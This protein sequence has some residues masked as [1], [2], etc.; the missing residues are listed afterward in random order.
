[1]MC[2][3]H[4]HDRYSSVISSVCWY[5]RPPMGPIIRPM[6]CPSTSVPSAGPTIHPLVSVNPRVRPRIC[7]WV[8]SSVASSHPSIHGFV[9][10]S[11]DPKRVY[12]FL[13]PSTLASI[14]RLQA[15]HSR[16][17]QAVHSRVHPYVCGFI[18]L[19]VQGPVHPSIHFI[20]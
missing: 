13:G 8:N 16:R 18:C 14:H 17:L 19:S 3:P 15:V 7:P 12:P 9:C 20:H 11:V 4:H 2:A 10:P 5:V 6:V 1:M